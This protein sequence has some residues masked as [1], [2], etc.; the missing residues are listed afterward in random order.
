MFLT[1]L[2]FLGARWKEQNFLFLSWTI[3]G[4]LMLELE[5]SDTQTNLLMLF[6]IFAVVFVMKVNEKR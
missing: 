6:G 3:N 1:L 2:D 4:V 5:K